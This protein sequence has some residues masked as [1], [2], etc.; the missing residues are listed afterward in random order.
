[1]KTFFIKILFDI[2]FFFQI[3]LYGRRPDFIYANN[4]FFSGVKKDGESRRTQNVK[5]PSKKS[6][7]K[8]LFVK[9][10]HPDYVYESDGK[11]FMESDGVLKEERKAIVI[12]G[13]ERIEGSVYIA[14]EAKIFIKR[15]DMLGVK[16]EDKEGERENVREDNR[17]LILILRER[18][19][20]LS[21]M[22]DMEGISLL[23]LCDL[24]ERRLMKGGVYVL[25]DKKGKTAWVWWD[26]K[27]KDREIYTL[28]I[29]QGNGVPVW[30]HYDRREDDERGRHNNILDWLKY[31]LEVEEYK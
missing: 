19:R 6:W 13:G 12:G 26:D 9:R 29:T 18:L 28:Y 21:R 14:G 22:A 1:M 3:L 8:N 4:S 11:V 24:I 10:G 5:E 7:F 25:M 27:G 15:A 20:K 23:V 31:Y 16:E 2:V 17:G 30:L